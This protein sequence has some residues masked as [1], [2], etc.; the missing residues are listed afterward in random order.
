MRYRIL[1][2]VEVHFDG[3]PVAIDRPRR[4]AVLSFLL[5]NADRTIS[6]DRLVEAIWAG[7][8]P[9][10]ARAQV[11]ADISAIRR[12]FREAGA[13]EPVATRPGGYLIETAPGELDYAEFTQLIAQAR[14]DDDLEQRARALRA[15]LR[16]YRGPALTGLTAAFVDSA[17]ARLDEQRLT[18]Y[19]RLADVDLALG[20]HVDLAEELA[21][22]VEAAPLREQL[23]GQLMLALHRG[24]RT[25]DA[26]AVTRNLRRRLA[27][28]HGL[29][30][31]RA[32]V[33]LEQQILRADP[34]LDLAAVPE[35]LEPAPEDSPAKAWSVPSQL[36]PD[37]VDFT[38]REPEV[39]SLCALLAGD[40]AE[41][42]GD[43]SWPARSTA[44]VVAAIAGMGGIGKTALAL[45]VAHQV[46]GAYPDGQLYVN[47]RGAEAVPLDCADVLG[48]FL[49]ALG[50]DSRAVP[51]ELEERGELYRSRLAGRKVLVVLDNAASEEQIRLLLPGTAGCAVLITSRLRLT[52]VESARWV[53]LDVFTP[54]HAIQ[55]LARIADPERVAAQQADAGEIARLCGCLPLAVRIAGAR[56]T[57][58]PNWSLANLA[59]MLS[60]E[61]QRLDGLTAGDLEVRASL[62]LSFQGL[63]EESQRLY[64]LL[65]LFDTPDF[66]SWLAA[67]V[68]DSSLKDAVTQL[69]ALVDAQLLSITGTDPAGQ[70][71]YRFHD[72]VRIYARERAGLDEDADAQAAAVARGLG[73]WLAI[74]EKMAD[75]VPGPCYASIHGTAPRAWVDGV[76]EIFGEPLVWFDAE[77][78]ALIS[79]VR[80]ACAL[81]LDELAFDLA[82]CLEKY[83]DIR[84]MYVDWGE[85]NEH[86]MAACRS[87]GN[88]RGEAVMLRGL[89][90]VV[91][92]SKAQSGD[93]MARFQA[94][95]ERLLSMFT[96]LAD[97]R[98]MADATVMCSWAFTAKG[99]YPEAIQA[100]TRAL[101]L[102]ETSDHLGGR[103]RA[104]VALAIAY[105][106]TRQ[107]GTTIAQLDDALA[108]T[109]ALGNPRY[110]ATVL[111]FLGMAHC[112]TGDF[113]TSQ[114]MLD[115]SLSI[116]RRYR[117]NYT[118]VL[119]M[120][121]LAR[122][123]LRLGDPLARAAAET[124]L[125]L[126][127][128][129]NM[130]HHVADSLGVLGEIELAEGHHAEAV[131][132]LRESVDMWRTRGWLSFLA[133]ALSSL[134]DAC[135]TVDPPAARA[136]WTEAR[137]LF[138]RLGNDFKA[139]KLTRSLD[140]LTGGA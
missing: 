100:G 114:R 116:S 140:R 32:V 67:A 135:A 52:G 103:A 25:A 29:D 70:T 68:L 83:F 133:A 13:P 118:E 42:A 130:G 4:R 63:D 24:G 54:S 43:P 124:S 58:R 92:W 40:S 95:A 20:R 57:A 96:Q 21:E 6:P 120:L 136:A 9:G 45:H 109:R 35:R 72:L 121:A 55:L 60:D 82:G 88:M 105:A 76:E 119:T 65:G 33:E 108:V 15:A 56:L 2:P 38:G 84:G 62:A 16:L 41:G 78:A 91:T 134:G 23:H 85:T 17:R 36:P 49:R 125:A 48:R 127:R 80:Q 79:A 66:P 27:D 115:A 28:E 128:H 61:R 107:I 11:Q 75:L 113:D 5:L 69:E 122:L 137:D 129:Y 101:L 131:G 139:D 44:L 117:D 74:A 73:A 77:R 7:A 50:V 98:G 22:V 59:R 93:A 99:A 39:E 110:E 3:R 86:V 34:A 64:R 12:A 112:E 102:A 126:G 31:G 123:Q 89:I 18:A 90:E 81:G 51:D 104:H 47:L 46:A 26:L 132:Y 87:A 19:E 30:L 71:R 1:G 10:S 106:E 97:D 37:I 8:A 138:T 94:A 111:Q 14:H 53:D